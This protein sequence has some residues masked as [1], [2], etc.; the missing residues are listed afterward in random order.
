LL[1][2]LLQRARQR[3]KMAAAPPAADEDLLYRFR[4]AHKK[5][6]GW[7]RIT[8]RGVEWASD[9]D[10][11]SLDVPYAEL[12]SHEVS[13]QDHPKALLRLSRAEGKAIVLTLLEATPDRAYAALC[14]AKLAITACVRRRRRKGEAQPVPQR[15][16]QPTAKRAEVLRRAKLLQSDE[17]LHKRHKELVQSGV[18]DEEAFWSAATGRRAPAAERATKAPLNDLL[19]D[20]PR[21]GESAG[22][23][24]T[25]SLSPEK[26]AFVFAM[27]PAVRRAHKTHV[28]KDMSEAQFWVKYF[29]S[30]YFW[31]DKGRAVL[32][33]GQAKADVADDLFARHEEAGDDLL[34]VAP[35][36]RKAVDLSRTD[37]DT[38]TAVRETLDPAAPSSERVLR[39]FNRHAALVLGAE[40]PSIPDEDFVQKADHVSLDLKHHQPSKPSKKRSVTAAF[41]M[42]D[43]DDR[44]H[45]VQWDTIDVQGALKR[46]QA[47]LNALIHLD[48]NVASVQPAPPKS[49]KEQVEKVAGD[50]RLLVRALRF[51]QGEAKK[52][53]IL[54]KLRQL[55]QFVEAK[56]S[57]YTAKP[58]FAHLAGFFKP[59]A[60]QIAHALHK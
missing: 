33:K 35:E 45:G 58:K 27:Y 49:T 32:E 37:A 18:V 23:T 36:V 34:Q 26:I 44:S 52:Q 24:V 57:G 5:R 53:A 56:T 39:K 11:K 54:K 12:A 55:A 9:R 41:A 1:S 13:P 20:A 10:A 2:S 40:P 38:L 4:A 30:R 31:R 21:E 6:D 43:D 14:D 22:R 42:D 28:P 46:S 16:A 7:C 60:D 17:A 3:Q 47:G 59:V 15:A 50:V 51:T 29:Q 19:V 48:R 8:A 25:F